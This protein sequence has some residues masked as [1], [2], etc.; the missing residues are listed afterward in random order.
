MKSNYAQ[1]ALAVCLATG[2]VGAGYYIGLTQQ[3]TAPAAQAQPEIVQA[4]TPVVPALPVE[5]P[6]YE[7]SRTPEGAA[8]NLQLENMKGLTVDTVADIEIFKSAIPSIEIVGDSQ[9]LIDT[10]KTELVGQ[11]LTVSHVLT[12]TLKVKCGS[13]SVSLDLNGNSTSVTVNTGKKK[14]KTYCALVKIG[15]PEIPAIQIKKSGSVHFTGADQ[16]QL[17]LKINGSGNI[18]GEGKVEDL[19]LWVTGSGSIDAAD[20][21]AQRLRVLSEGSGNVVANAQSKLE[22]AMHGS[23]DVTIF[24]N[25]KTKKHDESGSGKFRLYSGTKN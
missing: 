5:E 9:E 11:T 21:K 14:D 3:R 4:A 22:S 8:A 15:V 20:I 25:P 17:L 6:K 10:I 12:K 18:S 1:I 13:S 16:Q 19:L 24:G 7:V 23:G 2:L